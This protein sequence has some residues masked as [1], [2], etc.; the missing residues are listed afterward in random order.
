MPLIPPAEDPRWYQI[1]CLSGLLTYGVTFLEFDVS[2]V[3]IAAIIATAQLTQYACSRWKQIPYDPLSAMISA[4]SLCLILRANHLGVLLMG[5]VIAV[6]SKF[7]LRVANKHIFNPTNFG[8]A[9]A[10]ILTGDAWISPGQWG[11]QATLAFLFA[12]LGGFVVHRSNRMDVTFATLLFWGGIVIGRSWWLGEP[13]TIPFHRLQSGSLLLFSFFMISDPKT[14]PDHRVGRILF[15]FLVCGFAWYWQ[16]KLF[17]NSGLI[18]GLVLM[19]P[20][21]PVIDRLLPGPKYTWPGGKQPVPAPI[22][23]PVEALAAK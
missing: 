22:E 1:A 6:G 23:S 19:S 21:V 10:V 16:F 5:A 2:P 14:T 8:I 18:W 12:C 4:L 13:M 9:L 11:N 20:L 7:V 3:R 15:A 17:K